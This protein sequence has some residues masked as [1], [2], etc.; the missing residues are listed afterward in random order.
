MS[1]EDISTNSTVSNA[2]ISLFDPE[3][4]QDAAELIKEM[5]EVRDVSSQA[6]N[7]L[8]N[9]TF[10][11]G[12]TA[13]KTGRHSIAKRAAALLRAKLAEIDPTDTEGRTKYVR[14]IDNLVLIATNDDP[15]SRKE[16]IWAFNALSER[17]FG[18][19]MKSE[20]ELDAMRDSGG[21]R[22]IMLPPQ[23]PPTPVKELKVPEFIDVET[24]E[25]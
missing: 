15:K 16:A 5:K 14:M 22:I 20:E 17:A 18:A 12:N 9:G 21:V 24:T 11:P 3:D 25:S 10:G 19:P 13:N 4:R 2:A 8:P 7:R 23:L 6:E 1:T